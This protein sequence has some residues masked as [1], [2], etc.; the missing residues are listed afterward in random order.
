MIQRASNYFAFII[1][2]FASI[3]YAYPESIS[4]FT[5]RWITGALGFIMLVMGLTI[6]FED[7]QEVKTQPIPILVGVALQFLIMPFLGWS[8]SKVLDLNPEFTLGL[9]L[10]ASCP[11]GTASNVITYIA[12]G[13]VV[14]SIVLTSISTILAV[15]LTPTLILLYADSRIEI[16][17]QSLLLDTASVILVPVL[18]GLFLNLFFKKR[19][20][21]IIDW[22]PILSVLAISAIVSSVVSARKSSLTLENL[23]LYFAVFCLHGFGFLLGYLFS[24]IF[25]RNEKTNRTISIEVGMQNSGLGVVLATRNFTNPLVALPSALSSLTHSLIGSVL[26]GIWRRTQEKD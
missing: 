17:Y 19:L 22:A 21:K 10:V 12:R 5:G 9:I 26:A 13:N 20:Q 3:A 6:S 15:F 18:F 11:G 23:K 25:F 8:I 2:F 7:F 24:R 16:Q 1:L 4:W 14:L